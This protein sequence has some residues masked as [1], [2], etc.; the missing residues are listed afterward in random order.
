MFLFPFPF[1][2]P[3]FF[4]LSRFQ[5]ENNCYGEL[6]VWIVH[7]CVHPLGVEG[8]WIT[9][10]DLDCFYCVMSLMASARFRKL[11]FFEW[12]RYW[13]VSWFDCFYLPYCVLLSDRSFVLIWLC[14]VFLSNYILL[15]VTL[16]N[17][18]FLIW[19]YSSWLYVQPDRS[20]LCSTLHFYLIVLYLVFCCNIFSH[21]TW[22]DL[23][24]AP[25]A[26]LPLFLHIKLYS[27]CEVCSR[28]LLVARIAGKVSKN[29]PLNI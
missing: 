11:G 25:G 22:I 24:A 27:Y 20:T 19:L 10:A 28:W 8:K 12:L 7:F 13:L 21:F 5:H 9:M 26:M 2:S 17:Y 16:S 29:L 14:F 3:R 18:I 15:C 23:F 4:H 1:F 6:V